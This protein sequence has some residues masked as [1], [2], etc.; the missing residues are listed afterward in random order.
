MTKQRTRLHFI[1]HGE[2]E[3]PD[4]LRYGRLPGFHLSALGR[5][6][7][8]ETGASLIHRPISH[9]YASPLER[10]QQTATLLGMVFPHIPLSLDA[11]LLEIKLPASAEGKTRDHV[12]YYPP[13][14]RAD[15]E[16]A[17]AVLLRLRHFCEEK[18]LA[19][20]GQ[21]IIVVSHADP[22][23]LLTMWYLYKKVS[24]L[25]SPYPAYASRSTFVFEGVEL[26]EIWY[27]APTEDGGKR[28]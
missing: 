26:Q 21:E 3:N 5:T 17:E 25:G 22:I 19:Y 12:Y 28:S 8:T 13:E 27:S 23:A 11:R 6:Q 1:R 18:I 24:P 7:V 10:T 14:I 9:I 2:V 4:A 15:A 16:T 20:R